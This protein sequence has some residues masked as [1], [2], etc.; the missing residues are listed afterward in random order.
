MVDYTYTPHQPLGIDTYAIAL[1]WIIFKC[2][3]TVNTGHNIIIL[4]YKILINKS[5]KIKYNY[6]NDV[7]YMTLQHLNDVATP[8]E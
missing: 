5:I 6:L 4:L 3:Q 1:P 8:T 7:A 2:Q